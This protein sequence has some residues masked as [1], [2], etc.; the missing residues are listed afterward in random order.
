MTREVRREVA[1]H[2]GGDE[3]RLVDPFTLVPHGLTFGTR[4]DL[5]LRFL[6]VISYQEWVRRRWGEAQRQ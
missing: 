5:E 6:E 4:H 3:Y 2:L 1:V